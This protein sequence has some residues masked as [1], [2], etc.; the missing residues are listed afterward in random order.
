MMRIILQFLCDIILCDVNYR[1][2]CVRMMETALVYHPDELVQSF[3]CAHIIPLFEPEVNDDIGGSF[4]RLFL[5]Y[6]AT[7]TAPGIAEDGV[8][9]GLDTHGVFRYSIDECDAGDKARLR[10]PESSVLENGLNTVS[11]SS[12]ADSSAVSPNV[13]SAHEFMNS[14]GCGKIESMILLKI[15]A[16]RAGV[17]SAFGIPA[18]R[19]RDWLCTI[20]FELPAT[21][22][23][24]PLMQLCIHWIDSREDPSFLK[25]AAFALLQKERDFFGTFEGDRL[26]MIELLSF[27]LRK[28]GDVSVELSKIVD[29]MSDSEEDTLYAVIDSIITHNFREK[30]MLDF[31]CLLCILPWPVSSPSSV[32]C[33]LISS[34]FLVYYKLA[35]A[36]LRGSVDDRFISSP[37]GVL[38]NA[39]RICMCR[40]ASPILA[41]SALLQAILLVDISPLPALQMTN[42][43]LLLASLCPFLW[44]CHFIWS[45]CGRDV[46]A[47]TVVAL[48]Y[49]YHLLR[50]CVLCEPLS[51]K[52]NDLST[53][54]APMF[55]RV[56]FASD[57]QPF[58]DVSHFIPSMIDA[59]VANYQLHPANSASYESSDIAVDLVKPL[60]PPRGLRNLGNSC[61]YNS[62]LQALFH[63]RYFVHSVLGFSGGGSALGIYKKLF[64]KMLKRGKKPFDP[65]IGYKLFPSEWRHRSQQQ[66]VTEALNYVLEILDVTR[67][68]WKRVFAGMVLRR[69]RCLHCE[70][71]SDN[72]EVAMDFTFPLAG[73]PS[74]QEM[75]D[76]Y[77]KI[78]TL[79]KENR[80]FCSKCNAYRKA[81]MWNVITSPPSHLI[82]ILSRQIWLDESSEG[83]HTGGASKQ[84][85]HVKIDVTL[86]ICQFDYTLYG[87]IIHSGESTTSGHYYFVGRDSEVN[88]RWHVCDDSQVLPATSST[89]NDISQDRTNSHVPYVLFYRCVQAPATP[90]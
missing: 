6:K 87:A 1:P 9:I 35:Y 73:L 84:L 72:R 5:S 37:M 17:S 24:L 49:L 18:S 70:S 11:T 50:S 88:S 10:R 85:E 89:I 74:I 79:S 25:D 21:R 80:Y 64:R 45:S 34:T 51:G 42:A 75:F 31:W 81:H 61:Y 66:D 16:D 77:C 14:I 36:S 15:C 53:R 40:A 23:C 26:L 90:L 27:M 7:F 43:P 63:T 76:D 32:I 12:V 58:E 4:V 30:D 22:P 69:I 54:N 13:T 62:M 41:K 46:D 57:D 33:R 44:K 28:N 56:R 3:S 48:R 19:L 39:L 67:G 68:L 59:E 86:S 20:W 65:T 55:P 71:L 60:D 38:E 83:R 29:M 8:P 47:D 82:V 52:C 2:L 78:E